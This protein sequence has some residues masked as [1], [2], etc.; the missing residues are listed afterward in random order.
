MCAH[1]ILEIACFNLE[2]VLIAE[3]AGADRI[4]FC[5]D[6]NNGGISPPIELLSEVRDK[7]KIPLFVMIRPR[8]GDFVYSETEIQWMIKY[9]E[10]CR[11]HGTDG[12]VF[13]ALSPKN[14]I[15]LKTCSCLIE[16]AGSMSLTFHK[17]FDECMDTEN[18]INKLIEAGVNRILT[19]GGKKN[20]V[21]GI[22][23]IEQLQLS[24]GQKIIIMPGGGI[25]SGNIDQVKT[26]TCNE[27]HSSALCENSLIADAEEI[28]T[29]K[30]L[31]T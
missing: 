25:R 4:E 26:S 18:S 30:R 2:S 6:Y 12:I 28:Q 19:S 15:D 8:A 14:E 22:K 31:L 3:R 5:V 20:A 29:L 9:V 11:T 21:E 24:F 13:G 7:I 27:F 1:K 17:A 16:A 10:Q 23:K